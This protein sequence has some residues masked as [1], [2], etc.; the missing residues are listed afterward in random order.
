M[1]TQ[2][3]AP[4]EV[5][6][7]LWIGAIASKVR[8]VEID[9]AHVVAHIQSMGACAAVF[10]VDRDTPGAAS[11]TNSAGKVL[12]YIGTQHLA[13]MGVAQSGVLWVYR[14]TMG[15][16]DRIVPSWRAPAPKQ[17]ASW[18]PRSI[19]FE[20]LDADRPDAFPVDAIRRW[21]DHSRTDQ[22]LARSSV[23]R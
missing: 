16:W 18:A 15:H 22:H 8:E 17:D 3:D 11:L 6:L 14:D 12:A 9:K 19:G 5:S 1:P 10:M 23:E 4:H 2:Q 21:L 20:C 7:G 13:P